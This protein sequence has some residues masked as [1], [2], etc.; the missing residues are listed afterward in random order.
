[1]RGSIFL[2][3]YILQGGVQKM[4]QVHVKAIIYFLFILFYLQFII[5]LKKKVQRDHQFF[6][7]LVIG[8]HIQRQLTQIEEVL[9]ILDVKSQL[10][11]DFSL[12][13]LKISFILVYLASWES[14]LSAMGVSQGGLSFNEKHFQ[15]SIVE[16]VTIKGIGKLALVFK[17]KPDTGLLVDVGVTKID[18]SGSVQGEISQ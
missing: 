6:S 13:R 18:H 17:Y 3:L 4:I 2:H 7:F 1:M 12:N 10:F 11:V 9:L 5:K 15:V 8:E 14:H 16:F